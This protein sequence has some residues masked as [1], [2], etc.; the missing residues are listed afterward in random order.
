[1][2]PGTVDEQQVHRGRLLDR[3]GRAV[4]SP[5]KSVPLARGGI[6][7][8]TVATPIPRKDTPAS[9]SDGSVT[10]AFTGLILAAMVRFRG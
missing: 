7:N 10:R 4:A 9:L 3:S 8:P 6:L 2:H 5:P 1:M